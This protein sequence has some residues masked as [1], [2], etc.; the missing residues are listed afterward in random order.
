MKQRAVEVDG[1]GGVRGVQGK[2][3]QMGVARRGW[4]RQGRQRHGRWMGY[5]TSRGQR[6][7][8]AVEVGSGGWVTRRAK[9]GRGRAADRLCGKQRVAKGL[10]S[11]GT[12]RR[13]DYG[14]RRGW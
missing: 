13:M 14:V 8:Y 11:G 12:W 2:R 10:H 4:W 3:R 6:R 7:G 1:N 5:V 9:G